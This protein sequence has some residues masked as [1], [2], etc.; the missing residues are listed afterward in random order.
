M[1]AIPIENHG[2][3]LGNSIKIETLGLGIAVSARPIRSVDISDA[4]NKV[5]SESNYQK[6]AIE[7]M[8]ISENLNG[9]ENVINVIRTYVK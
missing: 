3:Q 7:L 5:M 6:R 1:V 4:I 8:H 9:I 2:E